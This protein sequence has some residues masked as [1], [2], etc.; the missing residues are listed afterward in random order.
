MIAFKPPYRHHPWRRT[1]VIAAFAVLVL[2]DLSPGGA[3][4]PSPARAASNRFDEYTVKAAYL[5]NFAKFVEWPEGSFSS[6]DSPLTICVMGSDPF[7][8]NLDTIAKNTVR[9]RKIAI[10]RLSG[11]E[12]VS[13]CQTVFVSREERGLVPSLID[14]VRDRHILTIGE[15]GDF[16][17]LGGIIN[18]YTE[19]D[20]VRFE[21]N[22][23]AAERAGLTISSELL[24]LAAIRRE[25][26]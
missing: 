18:L 6:V 16:C 8:A 10:K 2:L 12:G 14:A 3:G 1:I 9:G 17:R 26:K 22:I 11:V 19:N 25:G 23:D 21:I 4:S 7:K 13:Q 20:R 5:Y 15:A 24:K